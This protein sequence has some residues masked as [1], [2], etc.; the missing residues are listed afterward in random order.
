MSE[1]L[2]H[3]SRDDALVSSTLSSVLK[4][5]TV[6]GSEQDAGAF[7]VTIRNDH[8]EI[9]TD[10]VDNITFNDQVV[11]VSFFAGYQ[12]ASNAQLL[13]KTMCNISCGSIEKTEIKCLDWGIAKVSPSTYIVTLKFRESL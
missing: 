6:L 7:E 12:T 3:L 13:Y 9:L 4:Q 5:Q 10:D 11:E 8:T 1:Y 2:E